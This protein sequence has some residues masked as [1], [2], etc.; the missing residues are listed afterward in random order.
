[1]N[2]V[3][4][5]FSRNFLT[6][7]AMLKNERI[8]S[9]MV[10]CAVAAACA[11]LYLF[12]PARSQLYPLCP[13]NMLTGFHCPGC[14]TLRASHE[15]LH[16]NVGAALRLNPITVLATPFLG[17]A[18]LSRAMLGLRGRSLPRAFIPAAWIWALFG[19]ILVFWFLRN[20]PVYPFL[21]LA[22]TG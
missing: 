13:F 15:L 16:L 21:L 1:M 3:E 17:Y 6:I 5:L 9:A 22:P 19:V 20:L 4:V 2:S 8:M 18:L 7:V 12:D 14:G 11:V 10:V